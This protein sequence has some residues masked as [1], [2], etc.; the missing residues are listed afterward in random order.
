MGG[1]YCLRLFIF[2][3]IFGLSA[4]AVHAANPDGSLRVDIKTAY[5]LVV[6]SNAGTPSSYAPSAAYMSASFCN[7]GTNPLTDVY[8]YIG[9][10]TNQTP[11]IYPSR[12]HMTLDG[13]LPGDEFA[14][15]H[16]GGSMGTGDAT[17]YIGN[18]DPGECKTVY[19]LVSYDQVDDNGVPLWGP[20]TKPD[21]D[22][23]LQY[24]IWTTA[25]EL[26]SPLEAYDSRTVTFRNE[27]SASANKIFPN[28]A[29]KV[30]QEYLE[31]LG[32]YA[33]AWTNMPVDGSPGSKIITEGIWYDL[34]NIGDGFDNNGDLIPDKNAWMQPVGD[35]ALFDPS[36]FRL[37]RT[38]AMVVVKLKTGGEEVYVVEDQLYFEN[39]PENN[40]AVG[41]VGYE[42][43]TLRSGCYGQLTPYQ[44]VASGFDNEKFNADYGASLGEGL[45]SGTSRVEMVKSV[46]LTSILPG[47]SLVYSITYTNSGTVSIGLPQEGVPLVVQDSIPAGTY[48]VA[49]S[50]TNANFLPSNVTS[51]VILYSTNNGTSWLDAE[52]AA[53]TNVTDIQWR[54]SDPLEG[55]GAGAV[56]FSI[57]VPQNYT[58]ATPRVVNTGGLSI[59]GGVSFITDDAITFIKG[60]NSVGDTVWVDNGAGGGYF[61]N[62]LKDGTEAGISNVLVSLYYD[63]DGDGS[64]D[65]DDLLLSTTNTAAGGLYLFSEL[66]DGYY[67]VEVDNA[68]ADIPAGYGATTPLIY[69]VNLDAARTNGS[70]VAYM[71]A[72]FGFAPVLN[73][74]KTLNTT[75]TLREGGTVSYTLSVT[76]RLPGN[77]TG[78]GSACESI[79]YAAGRDIAA[80]PWVN[81]AAAYTPPYPDGVYA[82]NTLEAASE[83]LILT[84]FRLGPQNGSPTNVKIVARMYTTGTFSGGDYI[85]VEFVNRTAG[86]LFTTNLDAATINSILVSGD[87]ILDITAVRAWTWADFN[88]TNSIIRFTAQKG[89]GPDDGTVHLDA[90]GFKI[91]SSA[92]CGDSSDNN[93]LDVVPL[94]D[95]YDAGRLRFISASLTPDETSTNRSAPDQS[96]WLYWDNIG[97]IYPGGSK[98]VTLTFEMLEG[99]NNNAY[100]TVN[101]AY[102]TNAWFLN[103]LPAN[104]AQA[105]VTNAVYP[106]GKIGDFI[107]RDLDADGSQD[108][109]EPG[110]P[111]VKVVLTPPPGIDVGGG[112]GVAVTNTTS[113]TG[114]YYFTGI[115]AD[116]TYTVTVLTATL[117]GGTGNITY[118]PDGT[119]NSTTAVFIDYDSTTGGDTSLRNDFGYVLA[120]TIEGTIWHDVNR[121]ATNAPD[122]GEEWLT[123]V[124]VYLCAG[125]TPCGAGSAISTQQTTSSGYFIFTGNFTGEYNVSVDTNSGM[126]AGSSWTPSFD[127]DGTS[128]LNYASFNVVSGGQA[129]VDYSYW[130]TGNYSVGDTLFFDWDGDGM[131]DAYDEGIADITV[132]L[133]RDSNANGLI[134]Y[135]TDVLVLTTTTSSTGTYLFA[136]LSATNYL[137]IVNEADP[138]FPASYIMTADPQGALDGRSICL[139]TTSNRLDQDFGYQPRGTGVIGDSVW[140]DANAD[141]V[142]SGT[143]ETGITNVTVT[144]LA[145]L[146]GDGNFVAVATDVTDANGYYEFANLPPGDYKV[147]VSATDP[148]LP[149]DAFGNPPFVT[150]A[151]NFNVT[152]T[153]SSYLD[154]DFGFA[155]LGAIGDTIFWDGNQNGTQ[156]YNEEGVT[157]VTV[158]LYFDMNTNGVYDSGTDT[159]AASTNTDSNGTYLFSGL[160]ASSYVVVVVETGALQTA[161]IMSDPNNDGLPCSDPEAVGCDGRYG[162]TIMPGQ[163]FMGADFGYAP[164][165]VLGDAVWVDTDGDGVFDLT[166]QGIPYVDVILYSGGVAIATNQTDGDGYYLFANLPDGQYSVMVDTNDTD[167]P[168]GLGAV[169]DSAGDYDG[170]ATNIFIYGGSVTNIGNTGCTGC[171]LDVD[172]GYRYTGTNTLSGTI[173]LD[174]TAPD[175]VMGSGASGV[176][177]DEAPYAGVPVYIYLWN[178][179]GDRIPEAGE[180]TLVNQTVTTNNGDYSFADL[181]Q[182]DGNDEYLVTAAA[183]AYNLLLTTTNGAGTSTNVVQTTDAQG[184]N[185]S[186]RQSVP[187]AG[188]TVNVDFAFVSSLK[189]DFGDLPDTYSTRLESA[190][191]GA[192]HIVTSQTNLYLGLTIDTENNGTPAADAS[193]DG[194]DEDGVIPLGVWQEGTNGGAVQVTVGMGTGWLVGFVDFN[195]DGDFL[196]VGE[197][198]IN[199]SV[200][201]PGGGIYTNWFNVPTNSIYITNSTPYYSRFRLFPSQPA[202]PALSYYGEADNGEVED[203]YWLF[204]TLGDLVWEDINTNGVQD[205]GEPGIGGVK[206]FI[207]VNADGQWQ[208]GEP[209]SL[210]GNNGIYGIGGFSTGTYSVVVDTN[211]FPYPLFPVYDLDGT[212]TVN[213]TEITVTNGLVKTDIDFGY[214]R[215]AAVGDYVWDDLDSDGLQDAGE[216][217]MSNVTVRLYDAQ[218]NLLL[219]TVTDGSG[220]YGFTNLVP[221]AYIIQFVAP[222]FVLFS[223]AN[224]GGDDAE[225][226]DASQ[227]TGFTAPFT[228]ASGENNTTVDA[229]FLFSAAGQVDIGVDKGVSDYIPNEGDPISFTLVVSNA[230]PDNAT[231]VTVQDILPAGVTCTGSSSFA[232]STN[233]GVWTIGDLDMGNFTSL[234]IYA[235]VD[236]GTSGMIITNEGLLLTSDQ[237]DTYTNNNRDEVEFVVDGTDVGITKTVNSASINEGGTVV[238]T[239]TATNT[240]K[241]PATGVVFADILPVEVAFVSSSSADYDNGTGDWTVGALAAYASTSITITATVDMGTG[242]L[243]I[244]NSV[245]LTDIDQPDTVPSNNSSSASFYVP[246]A[247]IGVMKDVSTSLV[248]EADSIYYTLVV[249]N[250]GPDAATS[251][252]V[253]DALPASVTFV[254]SSSADYSTNGNLWTVGNL[255]VGGSTSMTVNVTVNTGTPGTSITNRL[256][257]ASLDQDDGNP[258]NDTDTA[259]FAV[260]PYSSI[261]NFVW[262]DGNT[263]NVQDAGEGGWT[264]LTVKLYDGNSNLLATTATDTSGIYT[265]TNVRSG[266]YFVEFIP[267]IFDYVFVVPDIGGN[268]ATDSDAAKNTGRTPIFYLP[269]GTN[270]YSWDA[271]LMHAE[272]GLRVTK[273]MDAASCVTPGDTISYEV[274]IANTGT[275]MHSFTLV[276]DT[277]P[278]GVTY[279]TNS[280]FIVAPADLT[281]TVKDTFSTIAYNNQD[282]T[283]D[284]MEDWS[285]DWTETGEADGAYV[286]S[287]KIADDGTNRSLFVSSRNVAIQRSMDLLT[288][289]NTYAMLSFDFRTALDAAQER[290]YLEV[291]TNGAA[292]T[293]LNTFNGSAASYLST[294]Y[295]ISSYIGT[296]TSVRF[297]TADVSQM[298]ADDIL[299]VDNLMIEFQR[300]A[301]TTNAGSGP[302]E[303]ASG[304]ML[305]TNETLT[306]TYEVTVNSSPGVTQIVNMATVNSQ[307]QPPISSVVTVCVSYVDLAI[308]KF[309]ADDTPSTNQVIAWTLVVTNN[310]PSGTDGIEV[311][312][313]LPAKTAYIS[314]GSSQGAYDNGSGIWSVGYMAAGDVETLTITAQMQAVSTDVFTNRADI[315]ASDLPD[316][317]PT[318]NWDEVVI[319]PTLVSI[320]SFRLLRAD[321]GV[322]VEWLTGSEIGTAGFY[323]E[324][325][326]RSGN[327]VRV[328]DEMLPSLFGAPLGGTY[329]YPD[330][331][332]AAAQYRIVEVEYNGIERIYGPFR[333]EV[334]SAP[335]LR[336]SGF[337]SVARGKPAGTRKA[338]SAV[339]KADP[340]PFDRLKISVADRGVYYVS[341]TEI[342]AL[343]GRTEAEVI[344]MLDQAQI[345]LTCSGTS[346]A[347]RS[348]DAGMYFYGVTRE[349]IYSGENVYVL[350]YGAG[351]HV[352]DAAGSPAVAEPGRSFA[353]TSRFEQPVYASTAMFSDPEED[354]W[355]WDGLMTGSNTN[356]NR[357]SFAFDLTDPASS[358]AAILTVRVK[359]YTD[360]AASPDHH[361]RI[362]VNGI[363]VT[364][365]QWNGQS[366]VDL[367]GVLD[368]G[369]LAAQGNVLQI[370]AVKVD[371]VTNGIF[372]L[373]RFDVTY[374]RL[375]RAVDD[376]IILKADANPVVTVEGF[377]NSQIEVWDVT[378]PLRP[379]RLSGLAPLSSSVSFVPASPD[380]LY[381]VYAA[382][383]NVLPAGIW[384]TT[385]RN[386]ASRG[387]HVVVSAPELEETAGLLAQY[388]EAQGLPAMVAT[389][390]DV[391]NEFSYGIATP[392]AISAFLKHASENWAEP[393]RYLVLAGAGSYDFRDYAGHGECMVPPLMSTTP[394]GLYASDNK[395]ADRNGDKVADVP[396]GRLPAQTPVELR[397]M[398]SRIVS[399]EKGGAW[400]NGVHL[401]ADNPDSGGAFPADSDDLAQSVPPTRTI[402]KTYL[403]ILS[404]EAARAQLVSV[405]NA[406]QGIFHYLGHA[407][408]AQLADEGILRINELSQLTNDAMAPFA[409]IMSCTA[410]RYD[411]PGV[412][413]LT[414]TMLRTSSG[415][416]VASWAPATLAEND[417]N[418]ILARSLFEGLF[419]AGDERIGDAI[420]RS[421]TAY[422]GSR[423]TDTVLESFS[424]LGDPA[425]SYGSRSAVASFDEWKWWQFGVDGATNS[426]LSDA[427][428]DPDGDGNANLM[429]FALDLDPNAQDGAA[430]VSIRSSGPLAGKYPLF[431]F[432]RRKAPLGT[433]YRL[434]VSTDI[435]SAE[436][437]YGSGFV[438]E[439]AVESLDETMERVTVWV[440]DALVSGPV[441][442]VRLKVMVD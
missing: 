378:E 340:G 405:L 341:A 83:Q 371:G 225:D 324:R 321:S 392:H 254:S 305:H 407:G 268:D 118:D 283:A 96:G 417:Q 403:D 19:W 97:P 404:T 279:V 381:A 177:A 138:D 435:E 269:A 263:N 55:G 248:Y 402:G 155:H 363:L 343:L 134:D 2:S 72:D 328:N 331:A 119:N 44:E 158:Q 415:G 420:K 398:L 127:T 29:N 6:D 104:S 34:G 137:V 326:N 438:E 393:P 347:Y 135:G 142:Q 380:R 146:N 243:F 334:E 412:D 117:P 339:K 226:S 202:Y 163:N 267:P 296:N 217:A 299:Y 228:L 141:G 87:A 214:W 332:G 384:T 320:A 50:A 348:A 128:T 57:L 295:N 208:D 42:F 199:Q 266:Y 421:M 65:A 362:T 424:L 275:V 252:V 53:A 288:M 185:V 166:E 123:N 259:V 174:G 411:V 105:A 330:R 280:S 309:V 63:S 353:E 10:Y 112:A 43:T 113:S 422:K 431:T 196:D 56:S 289:G 179:D 253:T 429:E 329:Q 433:N 184:N 187:V 88:T 232:Y 313:V 36:C 277:L 64:I 85:T 387:A 26:G 46:D 394:N 270:D 260:A 308:E 374:Q 180:I 419:S 300:R 368:G 293:L 164:P 436:W 349:T 258:T 335:E 80:K 318:N 103:G 206:V 409:A 148:S 314:Y 3:V 68:D 285:T 390:E 78:A 364:E 213:S 367:S 399:Y 156:D 109:L 282:G 102:T 333:A 172:F 122:P 262:I 316:V 178:D 170:W 246:L 379:V 17:R 182:G 200:T 9:D 375:Y 440:N 21:D 342:A 234:V 133:Y 47:T 175:G 30:P 356:L 14:L 31:L 271:G 171:S 161:T 272:P 198:I 152:L 312:D 173:G 245:S 365:G 441:V 7:D 317:V 400:K 27:I 261:G 160:S 99:P 74:T 40:G 203:Y 24:D 106:A 220:L 37:T 307:T 1:S 4:G 350:E 5:N 131:Q 239:L 195:H 247:D 8:A 274:E 366:A 439:V 233:T 38:Y 149:D 278:P 11:G 41:F 290:I 181:P 66:Y 212:G 129:R 425:T 255:A 16:E 205:A 432:D 12:A 360:T 223:P 60:T 304:Y 115:P 231:G 306:V 358:G 434:E 241:N 323:L 54:L 315:T 322:V 237:A 382:A 58:N 222:P 25:N 287:L 168:S 186:T 413:C 69:G 345:S 385:L 244:T 291:S 219:S 406:G 201:A 110:I 357:K 298:G 297:R 235:T 51:Y 265:F 165:G 98:S 430:A 215:G 256:S 354:F 147:T 346:V 218:T 410:G 176:N 395:L 359:G 183:P 23:W 227:T 389:V 386:G 144:L 153:N 423:R 216:P 194:A 352:S 230:G 94:T 337:K 273:S 136:N 59:G 71:S 210:T 336:A 292:W 302:P 257:V 240:T 108:A 101:R 125:T 84:D 159:I 442:Y 120:T 191:S 377:T 132:S 61:G 49:G 154:A 281:Y 437:L 73:L 126:M 286:G 91:Q 45:A 157:N 90:A 207:D 303:L 62:G 351:R 121:N 81:E 189:Y 344:S 52:P 276:T 89:G 39:I 242:G 150:T 204:G 67:I 77:G 151:T 294:N 401:S 28:G 311:T 224:Q 190:P 428:S 143:R 95:T 338:K 264:N 396:I 250:V 70:P 130:K 355:L 414:E 169:Y 86:T 197:M 418:I 221:S 388:R 76:N 79:I 20:S 229:G 48:Y 33:P 376:Q 372:Y 369:I 383:R 100:Q 114:F 75:N 325:L 167:F 22:L 111:N 139:V 361:A 327:F 426:T 82:T 13:P 124:T 408:S 238:F 427:F 251:V 310:G 140:F 391:Y 188:V 116:G 18:L 211:S 370:E 236:A 107:W 209:F 319:R 92:T 249:T 416:A 35:P 93:T 192:R 284:W 32:V 397:Q 373:D 145:D 162:V 193:G 15:A 301:I